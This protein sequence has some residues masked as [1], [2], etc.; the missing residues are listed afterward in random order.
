[1]AFMRRSD[2]PNFPSLLDNFFGRDMLDFD[3]TQRTGSMPAVNIK[4]GDNEYNIEVAA[5][6]MKKGD[7]KLN[8]DNNILTISS[9]KQQRQEEKNEKGEYTRREFSYQSFRRSF[10]LPDSADSDSINAS[11][12]DGILH[13]AIPKKEEA[14]KK[15]PRT[16]DIS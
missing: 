11:Y 3:E 9:E 6:G 4:E 5:P 1:M 15:E 14:K 16:I 10:T 13:I 8:L 2:F 12:K 7:F